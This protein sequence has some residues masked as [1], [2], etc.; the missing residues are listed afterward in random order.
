[1]PPSWDEYL[2]AEHGLIERI[3]SVLEQEIGNLAHGEVDSARIQQALTL[4]LEFGD[5]VHNVKEENHLFPLMVLRGV[6]QAGLIHSMLMDHEAERELIV[7]LLSKIAELEKGVSEETL[8]MGKRIAEYL[9][10]R[11]QHLA[12]EK[13]DIY[14]RA[15]QVLR[16]GDNKRLVQAFS[17]IDQAVYGEKA[18]SHVVHLVRQIEERMRTTLDHAS[19]P[20]EATKAILRA[21]P[22]QIVFADAGNRIVY[23]NRAQKGPAG[24][25][26]AMQIGDTLQDF[27]PK[28]IADE[29]LEAVNNFRDR[30]AKGYESPV[31]FQGKLLLLRLFPVRGEDDAYLGTGVIIG[32]PPESYASQVA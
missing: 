11:W 27:L 30:K 16:P 20:A 31:Q 17:K 3:L 21:L 1:M 12:T 4:L 28:D 13:K 7:Q 9:A 15:L 5:R 24:T 19:L 23:A 29:A 22:W 2:L 18:T 26:V 6:P 10:A 14:P 8:I 25:F 32:D